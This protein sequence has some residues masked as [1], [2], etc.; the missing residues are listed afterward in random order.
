MVIGFRLLQASPQVV[1]A[2]VVSGL[3]GYP[4]MHQSTVN[5]MLTAVKAFVNALL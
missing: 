2:A 1:D 5:L 3:L 4:K